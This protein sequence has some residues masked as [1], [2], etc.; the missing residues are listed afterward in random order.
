MSDDIT[1]IVRANARSTL[2][3]FRHELSERDIEFICDQIARKSQIDYVYLEPRES[4][5]SSVRAGRKA[6]AVFGP[7]E[8]DK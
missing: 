2:I 3:G 7:R 4:I 5:V 1:E 8:D 6:V